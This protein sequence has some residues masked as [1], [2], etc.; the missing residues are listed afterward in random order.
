MQKT[1]QIAALEVTLTK[2]RR[3]NANTKSHVWSVDN[4][5]ISRIAC[6]QGIIITAAKHANS[7]A[8]LIVIEIY[9]NE[10][11]SNERKRDW[12]AS[13][14]ESSS[15]IALKAFL[16]VTLPSDVAAIPRFAMVRA[17]ELEF[18]TSG[19]NGG[20]GFLAECLIHVL[21]GPVETYMDEEERNECK[22]K[23]MAHRKT[24]QRFHA[25]LSD[26]AGNRKRQESVRSSDPLDID[27]LSMQR[28]KKIRFR[29]AKQGRERKKKFF[30]DVRR[31]WILMTLIL[32]IG[33]RQD[34][35]QFAVKMQLQKLLLI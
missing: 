29:I 21:K 25:I 12:T 26:A 31:I 13:A 35:V 4:L 1:H 9:L 6:Y 8:N 32:L 27:M 33:E 18:Y 3:S 20:K 10:C 30:V 28:T 2:N 16:Y 22:S 11:N 7:L 34:G 19:V 14:V 5:E 23:I 17:K 15:E 24:V